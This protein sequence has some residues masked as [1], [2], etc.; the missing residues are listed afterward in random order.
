MPKADKT[1]AGSLTVHEEMNLV[2]FPIGLIGDRPPRD[3]ETGKEVKTFEWEK[4]I[5][6][7][8]GERVKQQ[9]TVTGSDKYGLPRGFD[10]CVLFLM[11]QIWAEQGF[12]QK[13]VEIGSIYRMLK[14][15]GLPDDP[16]YYNRIREAL[17]RL[18]GTTYYTRFAVW[19]PRKRTYIPRLNFNILSR[20]Q[21]DSFGHEEEIEELGVCVPSGTVEFTDALLFLVKNGYFKPTD[22]G[23]Y[24]SLPTPY[25]RRVFQFLDKRR[26]NGKVQRFDVFSF[27]KKLGT[28]DLTL[29][30]YKPAHIR[31]T[32]EPHLSRLASEEYGYLE[33]FAWPREGKRT[34]LEVCYAGDF[35][36]ERKLP[37]NAVRLVEEIVD[38]FDEEG[39]RRYY[40]RIIAELGLE[41]VRQLFADTKRAWSAGTIRNPGAYFIS[42]AQPLRTAHTARRKTLDA[43]AACQLCNSHG[44]LE[45]REQS[46]GHVFAHPCPHDAKIVAALQEQLGVEPLPKG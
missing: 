42:L 34:Y 7:P 16:H 26:I 6:L 3:P 9:W 19:N 20:V 18:I 5:S 22:A 28:H 29:K 36:Q 4:W 23:I 40:E 10:F 14:R 46:S 43:I 32:A 25:S 45:L 27:A 13:I 8:G 24:W 38:A 2:E 17:D 21:I 30:G 15:M 39:S 12:R 1:P 41:R 35:P 37:D 11:I 44:M 33:R 31:K